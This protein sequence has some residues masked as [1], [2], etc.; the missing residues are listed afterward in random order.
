MAPTC[1]QLVRDAESLTA[2]EVA[3]LPLA[4]AGLYEQRSERDRQALNAQPF[5]EAL[6]KPWALEPSK[7]TV[8]VYHSSCSDTLSGLQLPCKHLP[9]PL[10]Y[11]PCAKNIAA[12]SNA[13]CKLYHGL[14]KHNLQRCC[15]SADACLSGQFE[16]AY[17]CWVVVGLCVDYVLLDRL[18]EQLA[19]ISALIQIHEWKLTAGSALSKAI[20]LMAHAVKNSLESVPNEFTSLELLQVS[21]LCLLRVAILDTASDTPH[22]KE[23][24][25]IGSITSTSYTWVIS[26]LYA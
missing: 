25:N 4:L 26:L 12:A 6:V 3:Q 21:S 16:Q 17:F 9:V 15:I 14:P 18:Q 8:Q 22:G 20:F 5:F 1:V 11:K 10:S 2:P 23:Q 13:S 7:L 24:I 19:T